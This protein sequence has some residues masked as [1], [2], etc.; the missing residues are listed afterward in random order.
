MSVLRSAS[1]GDISRTGAFRAWTTDIDGLN[2]HP[3]AQITL[4]SCK[5]ES[6]A[7]SETCPQIEAWTPPGGVSS[8]FYLS[9]YIQGQLEKFDLETDLYQAL[10]NAWRVSKLDS[11]NTNIV[12]ARD[13][14]NTYIAIV[15]DGGCCGWEN[16][17]DD[18][19]Y[20]VSKGAQ[21]T[22]FDEESRFHNQDYDVSF[23][24]S[25][26]RFS[27]DEKKIAYTITSTYNSSSAESIRLSDSGKENPVE[28]RQIEAAFVKLPQVE[29]V[30]FSDLSKP[31]FSL[32]N[33]QLIGWL[34]EHRLLV[35][36]EGQLFLVDTISGKAAAT[37]LKA[38]KAAD[39]ILK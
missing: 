3:V 20:V 12:D 5:C 35:W 4:P 8:F 14:G 39:V 28:L 36:K 23:F 15:S 38:E 25:N 10:D 6:G 21:T 16:E 33:T 34:D 37:G 1:A 27:P 11:P 13:N 2:A 17:G 22:F 9:R 19:T 24:T 18:Q 29:V 30:A 31:C 26:A 7:C 32:V